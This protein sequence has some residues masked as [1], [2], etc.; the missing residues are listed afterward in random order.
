M[1][2]VFNDFR[3][4]FAQFLAAILNGR[5]PFRSALCVRTIAQSGNSD[6]DCAVIGFGKRDKVR[7]A[8][9]EQWRLGN[10]IQVPV[11]RHK[12]CGCRMRQAAKLVIKRIAVSDP[13][14][15]K[16]LG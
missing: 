16:R 9:F 14:R 8:S 10:V 4:L 2:E 11:T 6:H 3:P 5:Q 15:E 7:F 1:C 13:E 12:A